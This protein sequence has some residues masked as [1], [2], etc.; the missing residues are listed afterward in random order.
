MKCLHSAA[1]PAELSWETPEMDSR[2]DCFY[3]VV[4]EVALY[5]SQ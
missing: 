3:S 2:K 4:P 5:C 1:S